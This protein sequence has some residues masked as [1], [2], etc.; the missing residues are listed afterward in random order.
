[1]LLLLFALL[2]ISTPAVRDAP[3]LTHVASHASE[4]AGFMACQLGACGNYQQRI[5]VPMPHAVRA[6]LPER[7]HPV[8]RQ[9][10]DAFL[11]GHIS[12]AQFLRI[13][14]LPNSDYLAVQDCIIAEIDTPA[15]TSL[16]APAAAHRFG[17]GVNERA[18]SE[19][20]D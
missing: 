1:M 13:F 3:L 9:F 20:T 2:S 18:D 15:E 10:L 7:I 4:R 8:S 12:R 16:T 14:S 5:R 17:M 19:G 11:V 6:C